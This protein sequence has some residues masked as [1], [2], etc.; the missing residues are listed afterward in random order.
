MQLFQPEHIAVPSGHL[1]D[2]RFKSVPI[3]FAETHRGAPAHGRRADR[4]PCRQ[5]APNRSFVAARAGRTPQ[6][7]CLPML[8]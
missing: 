2:L 5:G 3:E 1:I 8:Q 4:T 6:A 7:F